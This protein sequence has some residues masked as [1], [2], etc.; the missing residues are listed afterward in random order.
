M[1]DEARD[2]DLLIARAQRG[3]RSG[4][5][6]LVR[7]HQDRAY[8]YA[9]RLTRN[10]EVAAD[11]VAEA[12]LRIHNALPNFKGQSSFKTWLYRILTNCYLDLRKR[13]RARPHGSLDA[14]TDAAEG[15]MGQQIADPGLTPEQEAQRS[16]RGDAAQVAL[17]AMPEYQRAM[18]IMYHAEDM[19]YEE[20]AAALDLP[21]GTVKSRLNRARIGLRDL[22]LKHEELFRI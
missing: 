19:S 2:D 18:I 21:V 8:T 9:Y 22:L 20:M 12:F 15:E 13:E 11:V 5:D 7:K 10:S 4:F 14:L 16:A 1:S 3:D 6:T 17:A